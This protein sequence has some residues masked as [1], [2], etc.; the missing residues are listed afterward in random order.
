MHAIVVDDEQALVWKEV[1]D[2]VPGEGEIVIDIH[3]SAL[4]RADLMQVAGD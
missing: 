1:P 2:P 4:N 3:A